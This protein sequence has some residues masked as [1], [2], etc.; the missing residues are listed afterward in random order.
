MEKKTCSTCI[1]YQHEGFDLIGG[2]KKIKSQ[3]ME[4]KANSPVPAIRSSSHSYLRIDEPSLFGC[5]LHEEKPPPPKIPDELWGV[6]FNRT[7]NPVQNL[8]GDPI[9]FATRE[10][11]EQYCQRLAAS[12][13]RIK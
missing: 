9:I 13:A 8:G 3:G 2:C 12:P 4:Q 1:H 10:R 5:L 7:G 11:A 6:F